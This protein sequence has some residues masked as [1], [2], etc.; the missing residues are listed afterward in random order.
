MYVLDRFDRALNSFV[1][2]H[3]A[4]GVDVKFRTERLPGNGHIR[5]YSAKV[6]AQTHL[7]TGSR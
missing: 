2:A 7:G 1:R 4:L 3:V 5:F 6:S